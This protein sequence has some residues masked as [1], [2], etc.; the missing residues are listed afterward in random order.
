ME[1][2]KLKTKKVAYQVLLM[3]FLFLMALCGGSTYV[4]WR[5]VEPLSLGEVQAWAI[6][7]TLALMFAMPC[8]AFVAF[9]FG[10]REA[11]VMTD[12]LRTGVNE[13]TRAADEVTTFKDKAA[14]RSKQPPVTVQVATL[15]SPQMFHR[16]LEGES[17]RVDL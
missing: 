16:Q 1:E 9:L 13:V 10:R 3:L 12:G 2:V 7:S 11:S 14:S 8:M 15:P 17:D 6:V 4:L 5:V